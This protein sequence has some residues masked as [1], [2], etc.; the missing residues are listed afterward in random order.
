MLIDDPAFACTLPPGSVIYQIYPRSFADSNG[1]GVGDLNGITAKLAYVAGL[2]VDAIWLSPV[3]VSPM[4]DFGYDVAD[5][6]DID[7]VFGTLADFDALVARAHDLGLKV[8]IDQVY[9]HTSDQHRWFSASRAARD[10]EKSDWYV[11]ADPK[12]DGLPPNNWQSVFYGPAWTFDT[13]RGQYYLHNFLPEQSQ[14]NVHHPAVQDALLEVARFWLARGVD[15]FRLD[16]LNVLMHDPALRDNPVAPANWPRVKP[17]DFQEHVHNQSQPQIPTFLERLRAVMDEYGAPFSVAE[18]AGLRAHGDMRAYTA[19]G[20][21]STAYSFVFLDAPALTPALVRDALADWR[22][23]WPA[24]AFSNHDAPRAVSRWGAGRDPDAFARLLLLLLVCLR[25][26]VFLYEGEELGLPQADVP[27]ERLRDP[28]AIANWPRNNGRDGART[29][30]PWSAT[31]PHAGFSTAEPWLPVDPRHT[32]RAVDAQSVDPT[33]TLNFTRALLR[34]RKTLPALLAGDFAV[35]EAGA[36]LL[37][38]TRRLGG[39]ALTCVFNLGR[40]DAGTPPSCRD[41]HVVLATQGL[42]LGAAPPV[43]LRPCQGLVLRAGV[44]GDPIR[45]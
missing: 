36:D 45:S 28:E 19:P 43:V 32:A 1:D 41:G 30:M 11:W 15:G 37:V 27:F 16:A 7:P 29:P 38:F 21:L 22:D 2:G 10:G 40:T 8:V 26:Y 44:V 25:G 4:A 3:F 34:A 39:E 42:A 31:A 9:C 18:V 13:R 5:Y 35:V 23:R 17:F 6:C 12:P 20:R 24:F 14:L 33:S